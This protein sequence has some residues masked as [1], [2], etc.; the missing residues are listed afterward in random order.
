MT[1]DRVNVSDESVRL[2]SDHTNTREMRRNPRDKAHHNKTLSAGGTTAIV[3]TIKQYPYCLFESVTTANSN[4]VIHF[5]MTLPSLCPSHLTPRSILTYP[6]HLP[7]FFN[8]IKNLLQMSYCIV[9]YGTE[10][11]C[12]YNRI[13]KKPVS[14]RNIYRFMQRFTY[15]IPYRV[16]ILNTVIFSLW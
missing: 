4:I 8:L 10:R 14:L 1:F 5:Q 13:H 12:Y 7:Q 3:E 16:L 11:T 15:C 2:M 9:V 6:L